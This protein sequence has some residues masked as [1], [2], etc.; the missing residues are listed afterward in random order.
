[1]S[2]QTVRAVLAYLMTLMVMAAAGGLMW[3]VF[4]PENFTT[5]QGTL[6]GTVI[7]GIMTK[8]GTPLSYFFDGVAGAPFPRPTNPTV[9]VKD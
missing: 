4:K 9:I 6:L 7:G 2:P 8:W 3:I 5:V 1:M